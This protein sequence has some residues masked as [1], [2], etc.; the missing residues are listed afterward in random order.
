MCPSIAFKCI[1]EGIGCTLT[2]CF[3]SLDR[4]GH[5]TCA[6]C[7]ESA[8]HGPAPYPDLWM[9]GAATHRALHSAQ[10]AARRRARRQ[11]RG[12]RAGPGRHRSRLGGRSTAAARRAFRVWRRGVRL[13]PLCRPGFG[14]T[15]H[16]PPRHPG[17][18]CIGFRAAP[19]RA[20]PSLGRAAVDQ[21]WVGLLESW[22]LGSGAGW[23]GPRISRPRD[24][25]LGV[26]TAC[27]AVQTAPRRSAI[28]ELIAA[29]CQLT[30]TPAVTSSGQPGPA[31]D[32]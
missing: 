12:R 30:W 14:A 13:R 3:Y 28:G 2:A 21:G 7:T 8:G 17:G 10:F 19:S 16:P 31:G 27:R 25:V 29:A 22:E 23:A 4:R 24:H 9:N 26:P 32:G 5:W 1:S 15:P 11:V 18:R 20:G 6:V